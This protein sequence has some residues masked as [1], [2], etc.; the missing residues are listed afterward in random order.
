MIYY[1][2]VPGADSCYMLCSSLLKYNGELYPGI[3]KYKFHCIGPIFVGRIKYIAFMNGIF[4]VNIHSY[5]SKMYIITI[6]QSISDKIF[7]KWEK[8]ETWNK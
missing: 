6:D 8:H 1:F 3:I 5:N 4:V 7:R 2:M